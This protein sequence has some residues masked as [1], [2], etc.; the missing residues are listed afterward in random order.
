MQ[1]TTSLGI[2]EL[3]ESEMEQLV[4]GD[5]SCWCS[6]FKRLFGYAIGYALGELVDAVVSPD[7]SNSFLG[8]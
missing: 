4:G 5:D 1:P 7:D 2:A 8:K 3:T 6:G